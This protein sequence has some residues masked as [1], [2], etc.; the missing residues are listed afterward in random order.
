MLY[1]IT[2]CW[3]HQLTHVTFFHQSKYINLSIVLSL[4]LRPSS[5]QWSRCRQC[6]RGRRPPWSPPFAPWQK[7]S[8][9]GFSAKISKCSPYFTDFTY[10]KLGKWWIDHWSLCSATA[11]PEC[12][13]R[14]SSRIIADGANTRGLIPSHS[15]PKPKPMVGKISFLAKS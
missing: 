9:W 6:R 11:G 1:N 7:A 10:E 15:L 13:L 12:C 5:P 4:L 8:A 2:K 3:N 14:P